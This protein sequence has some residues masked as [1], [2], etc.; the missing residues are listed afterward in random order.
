MSIILELFVGG[1]STSWWRFRWWPDDL[2]L[3]VKLAHQVRSTKN[4][5]HFISMAL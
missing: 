4:L 2:F 1:E 5:S 3:G